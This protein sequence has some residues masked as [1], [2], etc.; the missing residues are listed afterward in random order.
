VNKILKGVL[1]YGG[2]AIAGYV[3]YKKFWPLAMGS[4]SP[5]GAAPSPAASTAP[6]LPGLVRASP[7]NYIVRPTQI[8]GT[9]PRAGLQWNLV[10]GQWVPSATASAVATATSSP[11]AV[12]TGPSPATIV[13][14][15]A[16]AQVPGVI[17]PTATTSATGGGI[18]RSKVAMAPNPRYLIK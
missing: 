10:N 2:I 5:T 13:I 11:A 16:S 14:P 15:G 18:L 4:A 7:S 12:S 8:T 6:Q 1:I 17:R 9:G 3:L